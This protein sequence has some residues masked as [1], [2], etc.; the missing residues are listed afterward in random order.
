MSGALLIQ[1][2]VER[3]WWCNQQGPPNPHSQSPLILLILPPEELSN[4]STSLHLLYHYCNP[5]CSHLLLG[6]LQ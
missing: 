4:S 6:C 5:S 1:E 2:N 3:K